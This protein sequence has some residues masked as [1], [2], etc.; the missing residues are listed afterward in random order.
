MKLNEDTI[1]SIIKDYRNYETINYICRK[2]SITNYRLNKILKEKGITR[3]KR[4]YTI[5]EEVQQKIIAEYNS[6]VFIN[7][8]T[9]KYKINSCVLY[10]I[11]DKHNIPRRVNKKFK[12][13]GDVLKSLQYDRSNTDLTINELV[14]KYNVSRATINRAVFKNSLPKKGFNAKYKLSKEKVESI[15]FDYLHTNLYIQQIADKHGINQSTIYVIIK[16][17]NIP[18]RRKSK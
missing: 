7:S 3:G 12:I 5:P 9:K 10:S 11:L 1:N 15:I 8:I 14:D 17:N 2:Y 6:G 18:K 4:K 13:D 16:R